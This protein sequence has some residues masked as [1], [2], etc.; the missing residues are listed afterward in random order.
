MDVFSYLNQPCL[1]VIMWGTQE[2]SVD[3][4]KDRILESWLAKIFFPKSCKLKYLKTD[5][6]IINLFFNVWKHIPYVYFL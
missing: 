4:G 3:I 2:R 6:P 5:F 1:G